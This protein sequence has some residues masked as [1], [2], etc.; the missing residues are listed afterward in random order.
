MLIYW[1]VERG[2]VVIQSQRLNCSASEVHVMVDGAI[3]HGTDMAVEANY[4]GSHGQ[5]EIGFG[6]TKL[7]GFDLLPRIKRINKVKLYR[8]T[9]G[10]ADRWPTQ[11]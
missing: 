1:H 5:S 3:R 6:I 2:P 4:V 9:T 8:P 7:L 10:E 11:P